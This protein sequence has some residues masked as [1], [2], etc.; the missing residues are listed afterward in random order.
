MDKSKIT[1]ETLKAIRK[2][3]ADANGIV[4]TPAKCNFEGVCTGTCPA[5]E[6]E[7]EYIENQIFLKRKAGEIVKIA[8]LVAGLTTLAPLA[9]VAQEMSSPAPTETTTF[10]DEEYYFGLHGVSIRPEIVEREEYLTELV[11]QMP[12][13]VIIIAGNTDARGSE[14]YNRKLSQKRAEYLRSTVISKLKNPE[15]YIIIP[16]GLAFFYPNI[17][18]AQTEPEHEQNRR[19]S[20]FLYKEHTLKGEAARI[21][22]KAVEDNF[23]LLKKKLGKD[24]FKEFKKIW[25]RKVK[26][27]DKN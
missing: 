16:V 26:E 11:S 1:C 9:T 19:E 27:E 2:Q 24:R 10:L 22:N 4:Y 14:A 5:C 15:D 18:N 8:G 12:G 7:R 13:E 21:V 6:R 25:K 23:A 20:T 17:P 3:V